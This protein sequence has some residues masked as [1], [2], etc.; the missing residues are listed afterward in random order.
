MAGRTARKPPG[1]G[2]GDR[3]A[4]GDEA[5]WEVTLR[6]RPDADRLRPSS[7]VFN[8]AEQGARV[9][10][11]I[12][13]LGSRLDP[14]PAFLAEVGSE[15]GA[16][17]RGKIAATPDTRTVNRIEARQ[18]EETGRRL[19]HGVLL[20]RLLSKG[21]RKSVENATPVAVLPS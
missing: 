4:S 17:D 1:D 11:R 5:V 15:A 20:V 10:G 8:P 3:E 12:H 14:L 6:P 2:A 9:E 7:V 16:H 18:R 21:S 13:A 19:G